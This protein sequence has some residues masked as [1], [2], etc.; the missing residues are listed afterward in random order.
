MAKY[1]NPVCRGSWA[2]GSACGKCERCEETSPFKG[3]AIER[4]AYENLKVGFEIQK[5]AA[6][7]FKAERDRLAGD[8]LAALSGA[9]IP[10]SE[11]GYVAE[12]HMLALDILRLAKERDQARKELSELALK[13]GGRNAGHAFGP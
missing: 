2:L 9:G 4:E 11:K 12:P 1:K 3:G 8:A 5:K 6:E 10:T 13:H 7:L